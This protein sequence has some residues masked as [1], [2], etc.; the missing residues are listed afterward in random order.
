MP[1]V[2]DDRPFILECLKL[3]GVYSTPDELET[4]LAAVRTVANT[5]AHRL[6]S[7]ETLGFMRVYTIHHACLK[8]GEVV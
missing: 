2:M 7:A 8:T 6:K 3:S 4:Q 5:V 1:W